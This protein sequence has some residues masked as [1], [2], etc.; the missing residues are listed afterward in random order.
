MLVNLPE[1]EHFWGI[2]MIKMTWNAP[3]TIEDVRDRVQ[4]AIDL[5]YATLPIYLYAKMTLI[6]ERNPVAL[7]L[8]NSIV[9]EEMIHMCLACNIMNAIGGTVKIQPPTFPSPLPGGLAH[10]RSF[11][12]LPFSPDAVDQGMAIEEPETRIEPLLATG[13]DNENIVTIGQYYELVRAAL[14][15]LDPSEWHAGR[16][17]IDDAQFFQ[18]QIFAVNSYDDAARAIHE[19]VTEGEGTPVTHINPGTPLD[20]EG[21]LAHYYRFWEI[22]KNR[23]LEKNPDGAPTEQWQWGGEL[24]VDWGGVYPAISNP[25]LHDFSGEPPEAQE[26]Q[27]ACDAAYDAMV[28]GLTAAFTGGTGGLGQA[29]RAMFDLR[30][31]AIKALSTPLADG[32][33]VAGPAFAYTGTATGDAS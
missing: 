5:E 22:S 16:N 17:Q 8:Y 33:S 14:Q 18:G 28:D 23:V 20:F 25:R 29:V 9:G 10:D 1:R 2:K 6:P 30:M 4:K 21:D 13:V 26:A 11:N 15:S 27:K 31:A 24:G 32:T 12:L 7:S 3:A 19:I